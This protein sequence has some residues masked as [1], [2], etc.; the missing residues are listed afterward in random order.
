[1]RALNGSNR[2]ALMAALNHT[3]PDRWK[4][5]EIP[6]DAKL[7]MSAEQKNNFARGNAI[8]TALQMHGW[9]LPAAHF[10]WT[11]ILPI[12]V[13]RYPVWQATSAP[14]PLRRA[15]TCPPDFV[16]PPPALKA[17]RPAWCV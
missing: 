7:G 9:L 12:M 1:M 17:P 6:D 15:S 5:A 16:V 4:Y 14:K 3:D 8:L 13:S 10:F 2:K 11:F